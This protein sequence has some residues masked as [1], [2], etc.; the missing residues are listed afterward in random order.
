MTG[1][2]VIGILNLGWAVTS[3][4]MQIRSRF[5]LLRAEGM[6]WDSEMELSICMYV[7]K[8]SS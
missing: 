6:T 3:E 1:H 7:T 2:N 4:P 5:F 8:L